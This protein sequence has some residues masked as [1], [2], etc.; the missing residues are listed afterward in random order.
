MPQSRRLAFTLASVLIAG[1]GFGGTVYAQA[2]APTNSAPNPY[3]TVEG[4]A[5]FPTEENGD[6]QPAST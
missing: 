2:D 5:Q 3:R 1:G 6:R 4:W